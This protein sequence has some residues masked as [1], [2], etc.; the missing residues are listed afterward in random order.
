MA[1]AGMAPPSGLTTFSSGVVSVAGPTRAP[2]TRSSPRWN[3]PGN[4]HSSNAQRMTCRCSR[5]RPRI[6]LVQKS[7]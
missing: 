2:A 1:L 4:A 7:A 5:S 3:L 6:T